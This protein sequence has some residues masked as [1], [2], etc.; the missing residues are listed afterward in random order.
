MTHV[1][2]TIGDVANPLRPKD[3]R[4]SLAG[5]HQS[6][7]NPKQCVCAGALVS[8]DDVETPGSEAGRNVA[9]GGK[10][11]KELHQ[12]FEDDDRRGVRVAG[13]CHCVRFRETRWQSPP[14]PCSSPLHFVLCSAGPALLPADRSAW[15]RIWRRTSP[16]CWW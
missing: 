6:G 16:G 13:P 2:H 10:P 5:L 4:A 3:G 11:A 7:H 1:T 14:G 15:E 12:I 9:Q 8:Y